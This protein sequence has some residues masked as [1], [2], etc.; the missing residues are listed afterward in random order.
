MIINR[1]E[2]D[3][4]VLDYHREIRKMCELRNDNESLFGEEEENFL[5]FLINNNRIMLFKQ[6]KKEDKNKNFVP[7]DTE[8]S[9][10]RTI[11]YSSFVRS[12]H[13]L[14]ILSESAKLAIRDFID[15][16]TEES[17]SKI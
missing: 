1:A 6:P 11:K 13:I 4:N 12:K 2:R 5:K 15:Q 8:N 3:L 14:N 7:T 10:L 16:I 17:N 9:I